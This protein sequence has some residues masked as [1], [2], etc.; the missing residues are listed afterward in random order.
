MPP[1]P[2]R[3]RG[4]LASR[5]TACCTCHPPTRALAHPLPAHEQPA[6]PQ[7]PRAPPDVSD[8]LTRADLKG[9]K[10]CSYQREQGRCELPLCN[11]AHSAAE[12]REAKCVTG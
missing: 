9:I 4:L 2:V 5:E 10:M 7:R 3:V 12:Q 11:F 6:A 1:R 8:R